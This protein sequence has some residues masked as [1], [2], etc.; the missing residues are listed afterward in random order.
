MIKFN[1]TALTKS[2]IQ[3]LQ[4]CLDFSRSGWVET[5]TTCLSETWIICMRKPSTSERL[6]IRVFL[7]GYD[8]WRD[9]VLKK[10]VGYKHAGLKD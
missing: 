2:R 10:I 8:V 1:I 3:A 6:K 9:G 7:T 4:E 5:S